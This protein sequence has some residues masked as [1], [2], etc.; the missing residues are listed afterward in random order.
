MNPKEEPLVAAEEDVR[1]IAKLLSRAAKNYQMYLSNNR[2]FLTSL[3]SLQKALDDYLDVNDVLTFVVH[4]FELL[5]NETVVYSNSDKYQSIA[6][7]MYRDGIRLLSLHKGISEDDLTAFFEA[8]TR[9]METDNLEEDFVTLLWEKDLQ[10]ITYY[11]VNDFEADYERLKKEAEAKKGPT[12]QLTKAD[13]AD[14]PWNRAPDKQDKLKPSITLTPDDLNEVRGLTMTIDDDLFLRR[15]S[16]VLR[17]TL[18]TDCK[19]QT[20]LEMEGALNG[21]LDACVARKQIALASELLSEVT[22]RFQ[23]LGGHEAAQALGRIIRSRH[24]EKN[25]ASLGEVLAGENE[26]EHDHCRSYLSRLCPQALPEMIRLLPQCAR[27]SAKEALASSIAAVGGSCVHDVIKAL[28]IESG[29]EVALVLDVMEAIGT[30]E[31]LDSTLQFS[32]HGLP[33]V[34]TR[35]AELA[36]GL[37]NRKALEV[38]KRLITDTDHAVRRRALS[39]LV[40]ISGDGSVDTLVNLFTSSDFHELPHESKLSMLLSVRSLSPHGQQD[41]IRS[42]MRMRRFLKRKPLEDTKAALIEIMHLFDADV[43]EQELDRIC[44]KSSG[45]I[46]K[47]AEAA[48]E[49]INDEGTVG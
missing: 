40:E 42:L 15:A 32:K 28:N 43:A 30:E 1:E 33:K 7:R 23:K 49:K 18:E 6:F 48:L 35:V 25:M 38:V 5:H 45:R 46:R 13:V 9:C 27:T 44:A 8:L 26:T 39:S 12:K 10:A 29:E 22:E 36:A 17:L 47:A 20:Y 31:A 16:Q 24:S 3:E 19:T 21:L 34:R 14:A 37:G 4:E 11:E 2:M 41:V